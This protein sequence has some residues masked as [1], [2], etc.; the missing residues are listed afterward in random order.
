MEHLLEMKDVKK[1]FGG[2]AAL[3]GVSLTLD[4]GEVL[5]LVGENGAGKSTLMKILAG[6]IDASSGEIYVNGEKQNFKS[7]QEAIQK[8]ISVIYQELNYYKDLSIAENIFSGRLP[9]NKFG[10]IDW[11]KAY[12]LSNNALKEIEFEIDPRTE[13]GK[14]SIAQKQLVEIAKAV[15]RKNE[16]IVMDEPTAAL[17]DEETTSLFEMIRRLRNK[18]VSFIYIS[19]RLDELFKVADRVEV[20]R[21]G[22]YVGEIGIKDAKRDDI[23]HMMV[24]RTIEQM[25]PHKLLEPGDMLLEA[26]G[27]KGGIVDDVSINVR[28]GEIVSLFGLMGSGIT[29][30]LEEIYGVREK[31]AGQIFLKGKEVTIKS[32]KDAVK[33]RL[34]YVPPERKITGLYMMQGIKENI[35]APSITDLSK[36]LVMDK[37]AEIS[38]TKHIMD[39]LE[40]KATGIEAEVKSLSGGNQQK[41]LIGKWLRINP[42]VILVNEPTRGVEIGRAHV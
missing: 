23:V 42:T 17:N 21:D 3:K 1:N 33:N 16:I 30:L 5:A 34:A 38:E 19:H 25:Y 26:R 37:N 2:V 14:L 7:P 4:K 20:I 28:S 29:E 18:G 41:V 27:I 36:G 12:E 15:S 13:V 6:C 22:A 11:K 8:G 32:P 35:V 40:I 10:K 31:D 39:K 24:G 9:K